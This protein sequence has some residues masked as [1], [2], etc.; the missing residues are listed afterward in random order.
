MS[1]TKSQELYK[2]ERLLAG[3]RREKR[4]TL[5]GLEESKHPCFELSM[6]AI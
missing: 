5:A 4:Q 3:R 2:Q 1:Q 6:E